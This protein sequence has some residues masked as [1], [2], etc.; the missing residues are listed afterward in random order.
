MT[1]HN[2]SKTA[3]QPDVVSHMGSGHMSAK[4]QQKEQDCM[5]AHEYL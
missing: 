5:L 4:P 3:N 2:K 1:L